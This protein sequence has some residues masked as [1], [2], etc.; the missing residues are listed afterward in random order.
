M[1]ALRKRE[2]FF[3]GWMDYLCIQTTFAELL[4][5]FYITM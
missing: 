1:N 4:W 2:A 3:Y 5:I